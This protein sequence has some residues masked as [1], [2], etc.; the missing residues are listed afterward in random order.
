MCVNDVHLGLHRKRPFNNSSSARCSLL[1]KVFFYSFA[2]RGVKG[3][4]GSAPKCTDYESNGSDKAKTKLANEG[5]QEKEAAEPDLVVA[6][7][8]H[9]VTRSTF[10]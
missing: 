8:D 1:I 7:R 3:S 10:V 5:R 4:F 6:S 2:D 9:C